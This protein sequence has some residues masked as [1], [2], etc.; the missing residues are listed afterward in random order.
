MKRRLARLRVARWVSVGLLLSRFAQGDP[1]AVVNPVP[2]GTYPVG[3][4]NVAQDYSRL[5]SGE[6]AQE[7]WD[8]FPNGGQERYVSQLLVDPAAAMQ[9]ALPIPNDSELFVDRGGSAVTYDFLVCY[10]TAS[11]NPNPD[12]PLPTGGVVPHMQAGSSA[13]TWPDATT[14]WP[15]L[16]FSHGLAGSPLDTPYI[17]IIAALASYGY[18]VVA[19]FHGDARFADVQ[20]QN[21]VDLIYAVLHFPTYVEMQAIRPLSS[22]AALDLLLSNPDYQGH[23]DAN[24]IAGFGAS[25]GGETLL[26]QAG[27]RLTDSIG[28][29]S[30]QVV[31][32]ARLKA[33]FGYVP[34]FGQPIYPAFG[35]DQQGLDGMTVPFLGVS[36]TADTTAPVGPALQGVAQLGGSR[37]LVTLQ[38][39]THHF[40]VP[41]TDTIF[42]WALIFIRAQAQDDRMARVTLARMTHV[43]DG[44]QDQLLLDYTAPAVPYLAGESDVVEYYRGATGHYFITANPAETVVLDAGGA[45]SRTGFEFKAFALGSGLGVDA[46]RFFSAPALSP[47]S[48]FFTIDANECAIVKASP[49]WIYEGLAFAAEPPLA[50]DSCA[51]N[52]IAVFRLYNNGMNGQP[53]HRFLTSKSETAATQAQGWALEGTVFCSPP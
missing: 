1:L 27:A 5:Q 28:L 8:G 35:R 44:G 16:L 34:Y 32:D 31:V 49:L 7:Y 12:Y 10:P 47:D 43:A 25:L 23:V 13:P 53:N 2:P 21:I 52:R 37:Y 17:Q 39:V 51:L 42:T 45:W 48:H 41:S 22:V 3:C 19:P 50:D 29:S 46:C 9:V 14:V 18:V 26:L 15:V 11:T 6:T 20:I 24:R 36:G 4:S 38:G 33:I 30:K 40:D